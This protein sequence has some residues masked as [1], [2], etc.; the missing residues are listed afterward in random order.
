MTVSET[1]S[2]DEEE[3]SNED[4]VLAQIGEDP[5]LPADTIEQDSKTRDNEEN[6]QGKGANRTKTKE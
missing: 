2:K 5:G 3:I 6:K 4:A 1:P